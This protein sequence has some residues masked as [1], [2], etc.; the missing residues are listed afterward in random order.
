M[1]KPLGLL[2]RTGFLP[3]L[4]MLFIVTLFGSVGLAGAAGDGGSTDWF[5][6]QVVDEETGRGVPLVM[7]ETID[8][9]FFVTDSAGRIAINEPG[10][11]NQVVFFHMRSHGY[12]MPSL[13]G[14][15]NVKGI[16]VKVIPG[17]ETVV[18][19][20][21]VNMAERLYRLTGAGIYNDS[22]ILGKPVPIEKPVLNAEVT[23]QDGGICTIY[24]GKL[25]WFWGDT[26]RLSYPLGNF[27][28]TV[29]TSELPENGGLH[30]SVGMNFK[31]FERPDG[32]AKSMFPFG[33]GGNMVWAASIMKLPDETG[34]E[35]LILSYGTRLADWT[36]IEKGLA[37]YDEENEIF[38]KIG[39]LDLDREWRYPDS[40]GNTVDYDDGSGEDWLYFHEGVESVRAPRDLKALFDPDSYESW[41]CLADGSPKEA[42]AAKL[43]RDE[44]G[45]LVYRWTSKAPPVSSNEELE[46]IRAGLMDPS[47]AW[48]LPRDVDTGKL[49]NL[50]NGSVKWNPWRQKWVMIAVENG[51]DTS[52]LGEIWYTEA[53]SPMGPWKKAK[54]IITHNQYSMYNPVYHGIFDEEGGRI[55]YFEGCYVISFSTSEENATPLYNYNMV[56]YRLDLSDPRLREVWD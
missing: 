52:A 5:C 33:S 18:K 7:L 24:D 51:G 27:L 19:V 23:G 2:K 43:N 6:I 11:M 12:S 16:E 38:E 49:V 48:Y 47:E 39:T 35:R 13:E 36:L 3:F 10:L 56:M 22:V 14:Y 31:Y 8:H 30:P 55:I 41:T 37:W 53:D 34:K 44:N 54:K 50:H 21:R 42:W 32:F 45:K 46:Y 20:K 28:M 25:F 1:S 4:V 29:A 15:D 9:R 26:N 17:G 40:W